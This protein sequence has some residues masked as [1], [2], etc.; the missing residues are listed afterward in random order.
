MPE[1]QINT[2]EGAVPYILNFSVDGIRSEIMLHYL[3]SLGV[4]VSSGSACSKGEKSHVL[5][6]MGLSDKR[7]DT[8]IRVSFGAMTSPEDI[9][10]LADGI[11][12]GLD[13]LIRI[14]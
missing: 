10:A 6:A 3:E 2:P 9:D 8:A 14:K 7:A 5:K 12:A 13:T 1:V 4:Y 11:R